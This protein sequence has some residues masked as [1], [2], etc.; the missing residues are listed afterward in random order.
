MK[1]RLF[2]MLLALVMVFLMI[3]VFAAPAAAASVTVDTAEKLRQALMQD[4]DMNIILTK[5]IT[6]YKLPSDFKWGGYD[7]E[8][9][10]LF[11]ATVGKGTKNLMLQGHDVN[12][13]DDFVTTAKYQKVKRYNTETGKEYEVNTLIKGLYVQNAA[14]LR[15]S[16]GTTLNIYGYGGGM[17]MTAQI[18]SKDQIYD[19]RIVM[20]RDVF[21]VDGGELNVEGGTYQAGRKKEIFVSNSIAK[22]T[23][24]ATEFLWGDYA[25]GDNKNYNG[26]GEYAINGVALRMY[27]GKATING[28]TFK[29]HGYSYLNSED[30][31]F[32]KV[33]RNSVLSV[34]GGD[35]SIRDINVIGYCGSNVFYKGNSGSVDI[36]AGEFST[37]APDRFLWP[38]TNT[39]GV[40]GWAGYHS[41]YMS[42]DV[43]PGSV[44]IAGAVTH[45]KTSMTHYDT[46]TVVYPAES[47]FMGGKLTWSDGTTDN[48]TYTLGTKKEVVFTPGETY[49]PEGALSGGQSVEYYYSIMVQK[50]DGKWVSVGDSWKRG[51]PTDEL[52]RL[53][54]NWAEGHNY[55]IW[56]KTVEYWS[57]ESHSYQITTKAPKRLYFTVNSDK[58]ITNVTVDG[59]SPS[60]SSVGTS[61]LTSN[62]PGVKSVSSLWY[63]NGS[64]HGGTVILSS[65]EYQASVTLTAADGYVFSKNTSI[66]IYGIPGKP[67]YITADGK[68]VQIDSPVI[69]KACDHSGD[70]SDWE[71]NTQSHFK[72][73][74]VCGEVRSLAA[75][76]YSAGTSVG[77]LTTY[78]CTVCGYEKTE[79]NGKEA[80]NALLLDMPALVVGEKLTTPTL[81]D[82]F[83]SKASITSYQ[84]YKGNGTTDKVAVGSTL[85]KGWYTIEVTAKAGSGYYFKN[86]AF[87]THSHGTKA[88]ATVSDTTITGLVNV[89]CSESATADIKIPSLTPNKTLGDV[90]RGV[91]VSR[92]GVENINVN[93][94]VTWDGES[95]IVKRSFDGKW[96]VSGTDESLDQIL[97][98]Q[99]VPNTYY[100]IE[101]EFSLGNYYVAPEKITL[102]S[103]S[104]LVGYTTDSNDAWGS[105]K[106]TIISGTD[107]INIIDIYGVTVPTVGGVPNADFSLYATDKIEKVS[108]SWDTN[109]KFECGLP[110]TFTATV[111]AVTGY[112]FESGAVATVNG[113]AA[114]LTFDEDTATITFNFEPLDHK[115]S[116][117]E[118]IK[119]AS[120]TEG[121]LVRRVCSVCG[122]TEEAEV[123]ATGHSFYEVTATPS[124]CS[125][126]GID[127]HLECTD[128]DRL[129]DL[130]ENEV[131]Q[132]DLMLP[133][134][135]DEHEGG[136]MRGD[137]D[138]HY[139]LCA[140]GE[141]LEA[142][143]HTFGDWSVEKEAKPGVEGLRSHDCT[144]C[145][146]VESEKIDALPGEHIH[147]FDLIS[148]DELYHWLVCECGETA[149]KHA[150]TYG[151]DDVCTVC[152]Y[153]KTGDEPEVTAL[154][155]SEGTSGTSTEPVVQPSGSSSTGTSEPEPSGSSSGHGE[156]DPGKQK[157]A[158]IWLWILII[159]IVLG[160][161]AAAVVIITKKKQGK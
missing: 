145:G 44:S 67:N 159:I 65:G 107:E 50:S 5:D 4:G 127:F 94:Y 124:T 41:N 110:Y 142:A 20:Q 150:H 144:V 27:G 58:T 109:A 138:G 66:S 75:H 89:Y 36:Y 14:L 63:E 55:S 133:L 38:N 123:P 118:T 33:Y 117:W 52:S 83:R 72:H 49:F 9:D 46:K 12:I 78:T 130:G 43:K 29:G 95:Y 103:K 25:I 160:G 129:F 16:S 157:G 155:T 148:R 7:E 1:K 154:P 28:G 18:P 152:D 40:F 74:S 23:N 116:E 59:F 24:W 140:C 122:E 141:K 31:F 26:Y 80:I 47:G 97:S 143:P 32:M 48:G 71:Y 87:V 54:D 79:Q 85:E 10:R 111:R 70:T 158:P 98:K 113:T 131:E 30:T 37:K 146:Y 61:T 77:N 128:C 45:N 56:I 21:F 137:E 22:D 115:F 119:E 6:G 102:D 60:A 92:S 121:G 96:S 153:K 105:A 57:S 132:D 139:I 84:W 99:I 51:D 73:C 68:T 135:P 108:S 100:E 53:N 11:W 149:E 13:D 91:V 39:S 151:D 93:Y 62:T 88:G 86:N 8:R 156:T 19:N 82:E 76:T 34:Y 35:L 42:V 2:S 147:S 120:C 90:L 81:A 106:A 114:E 134:D 3:P 161:G 64:A 17:A 136:E 69:N 126:H 125:T 15:I 104:F 112:R 101:V